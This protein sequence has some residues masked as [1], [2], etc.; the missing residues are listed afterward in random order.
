M[1]YVFLLLLL[2]LGK[3]A[4]AQI[5]YMDED[6]NGN[7]MWKEVIEYDSLMLTPEQIVDNIDQWLDRKKTLFNTIAI[8]DLAG[9]RIENNILEKKEDYIRGYLHGQIERTAL[10]SYA[11]RI[12]IDVEVRAGRYRVVFS[13][14][15][16]LASSALGTIIIPNSPSIF[17]RKEIAETFK[18]K[19]GPG[20][21]DETMA[22]LITEI[23]AESQRIKKTT[24]SSEDW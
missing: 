7:W 5:Q 10:H 23:T 14:M 15:T 3:S 17:T 4:S 16:I 24:Q 13:E 6:V 9:F 22:R 19:K 8:G 1:K 11:V 2:L 20:S 18:K 21:L 12:Y